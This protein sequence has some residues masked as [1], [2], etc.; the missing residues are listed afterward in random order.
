MMQSISAHFR[1]SAKH[2]DQQVKLHVLQ[3][4]KKKT[5]KT[6]GMRKLVM[7]VKLKQPKFYSNF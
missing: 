5:K 7:L 2:T 6:A 3:K 1:L 4:N